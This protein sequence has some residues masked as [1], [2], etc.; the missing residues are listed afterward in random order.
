MAVSPPPVSEPRPGPAGVVGRDVVRRL[1]RLLAGLVLCG[2]G[3]ALMVAADLGLAPWDVLHQGLSERTGIPIGTMGILVGVVVLLAWI[4]LRERPGIGTICNVVVI[5]ATIDLT[6]LVLPSDPSAPLRVGLLVL[7][8]F[9]FG[10]GSGLYIGVRLG[11]GPRDGV[12]TGLARR[13]W[14]VRRARTAIEV[15]VLAL[16]FALGGSVGA[17]TLL[18][19][20]TIGPNVHFFLDRWG[21]EPPPSRPVVTSAE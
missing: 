14:S 7:G 4:P 15:T 12:M 11:A 8:A 1:P 17:G 16:G 2:L 3:I 19:A 10:P 6:L 18:F 13:G 21:L 20:L 9:L 5:G